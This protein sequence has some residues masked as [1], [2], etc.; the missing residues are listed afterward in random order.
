MPKKAARIFLKVTDIRT[1]WLKDISNADAMDEGVLL[2]HGWETEEYREAVR[3]AHRDGTKPPLGLAP[4]ERFAHL[5]D[6][7][8]KPENRQRFGWQANPLVWVIKFERISRE[9]AE[10]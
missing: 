5:W 1:E 4:K 3:L 2:Y 8:V 9:E 10:A 6:S 7:T